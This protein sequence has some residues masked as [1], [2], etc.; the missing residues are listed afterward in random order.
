[1]IGRRAAILAAVVLFAPCARAQTSAQDKAVADALFRDGVRLLRAGSL[2]DACPKLAESERIDPAV[3]TAL[4]LGECYERSG[5]IASAQ[6][7]FQEGYDFALRRGDTRASVAKDHHDKLK[8]STLT[9]ALARG[10]A[11][12]GLEIRRDDIAL[13]AAEL[14]LALPADGGVHVIVAEAPGKKPYRTTVNVPTK[15]GA[16]TVT[17]P[18]LADEPAAVTLS[19]PRES[20]GASTSTSAS[21]PSATS[22]PAAG[23][24]AIALAVGGAGVAG[25]VLGAAAGLVALADWNDSNSADNGCDSGS[26]LCPTQH[27]IDLRASAKDWAT[28]STVAFAAGGALAVAGVILFFTAPKARVDSAV[29]IAP[30]VFGAGGGAV[31]RGS[32]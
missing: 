26:T 8:P 13:S 29:T 25:I 19:A 12:D 7:M 2:A 32:F 22:G 10:A 1:L 16:V 21:T 24:R 3:G 6:A 17:I 27:G 28:V 20:T 11:S 30:A 4:Y 5:R 23:R 18:R 14:G 15:E 31:V 9:I